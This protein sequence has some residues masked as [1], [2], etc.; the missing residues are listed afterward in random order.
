MYYAM[1]VQWCCNMVC[2]AGGG[3]KKRMIDSPDKDRANRTL[4]S[5]LPYGV[6]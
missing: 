1:V 2:F 4:L 3:V 6:A 5:R